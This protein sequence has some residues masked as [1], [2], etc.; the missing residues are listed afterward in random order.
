[1]EEPHRLNPSLPDVGLLAQIASELDGVESALGRID[2]GAYGKCA[3][4]GAPLDDAY[5]EADP[6]QLGCAS[7]R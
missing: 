3:Q 6:L 1:M 4:C 7:H 5:L 2:T